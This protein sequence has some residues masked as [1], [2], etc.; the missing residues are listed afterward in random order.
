[1][2]NLFQP[3]TVTVET[4]DLRDPTPAPVSAPTPL[5]VNSSSMSP[6]LSPTISPTLSSAPTGTNI[7]GYGDFE[8]APINGTVSLFSDLMY[9]ETHFVIYGLSNSS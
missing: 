1:M 4:V 7:L 9:N 2:S 8:T 5:P 3:H 6:V